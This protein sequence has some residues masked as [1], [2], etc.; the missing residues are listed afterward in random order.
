VKSSVIR[1]ALR[2]FHVADAAALYALTRRTV[3]LSLP[4]A[5]VFAVVSAQLSPT[6]SPAL[7]HGKKSLSSPWI[8][9]AAG[10][11]RTG[12]SPD[13]FPDFATNP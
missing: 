7:I 3:T 5:S 4:V 1:T 9:T 2:A 13:G 6:F 10:F 8:C 11:A 12:C